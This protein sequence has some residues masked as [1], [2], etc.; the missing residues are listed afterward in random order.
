MVVVSLAFDASLSELDEFEGLCGSARDLVFMDTEREIRGLQALQAAR[1]HRVERSGSF[2]DDGYKGVKNWCRAVTNSSGPTAARQVALARMFAVLP[3][4]AEAA[5]DGDIGPDQLQLFAGLFANRRCREELVAWELILLGYARMFVFHEFATL[6]RRWEARADPDGAEQRHEV[7]RE[8]RHVKKS[9]VGESSLI[10]IA[11]DA[12][13]GEFCFEVIEAHAEAEYLADVALRLALYGNDAEDHP[14]ARTHPQRMHDAFVTICRKAQAATPP[15]ASSNEPLVVIHTTPDVVFEALL[16]FFGFDP[17]ELATEPILPGRSA[18]IG[19]CETAGGAPVDNRTL[20][21]ALLCGRVQRI[22]TDLNGHTI[23][24]GRKQ[25]LFTGAARDAV[26]LNE[27][28][29]S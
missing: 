5:A 29:C 21:V 9:A 8:N 1:V 12:V 13:S 2:L 25:R 22:V 10:T 23:N 19:F 24:L 3:K 11:G 18:R 27:D 14:L 26:L 17:T 20:A 16:A 15:T 6:C 28:R 4:I 7:A